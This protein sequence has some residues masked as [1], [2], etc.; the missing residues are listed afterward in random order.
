MATNGKKSRKKLIIF[1]VIGLV[2]IV[3]VFIDNLR[4]SSAT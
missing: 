4:R 1:S 2:I 3:A